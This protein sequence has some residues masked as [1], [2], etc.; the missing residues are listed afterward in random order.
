[1]KSA[2]LKPLSD[3]D[4][5]DELRFQI[6]VVKLFPCNPSMQ[7]VDPAKVIREAIGKALMFYYPLAG[8][9]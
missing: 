6:P 1:M 3:I 7:G 5:Q 8:R 4:G 2:L 9:L